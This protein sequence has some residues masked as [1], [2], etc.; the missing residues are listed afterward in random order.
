MCKFS[1]F[2]GYTGLSSRLVGDDSL[3]LQSFCEHLI[4]STCIVDSMVCY[5]GLRYNKP[6]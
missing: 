1:H 2:T 5:S 3:D 6:C 4:D